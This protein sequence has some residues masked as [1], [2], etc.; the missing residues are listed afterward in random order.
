MVVGKRKRF[1]IPRIVGVFVTRAQVAKLNFGLGV[2]YHAT[3]QLIETFT[4]EYN[5][6]GD[7]QNK[8]TLPTNS[9]HEY[10]V[11]KSGRSEYGLSFIY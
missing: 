11:Y 7:R 5:R 1:V 8:M 4:L 2:L 3:N 6:Y 9:L 10:P